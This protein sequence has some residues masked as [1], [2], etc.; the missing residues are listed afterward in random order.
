M[1]LI[2]ECR[3][4]GLSDYQWCEQQGI[5]KLSLSNWINRLR[6]ADYQFPNSESKKHSLPMKW[7]L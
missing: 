6:K 1:M 2:T 5:N 7:K 4:S 3:T